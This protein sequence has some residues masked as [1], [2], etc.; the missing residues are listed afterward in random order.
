MCN[1]LPSPFSQQYS[2]RTWISRPPDVPLLWNRTCV[3]VVCSVSHP[4]VSRHWRETIS[5]ISSPTDL[6]KQHV[7]WC[8]SHYQRQQLLFAVEIWR[9]IPICTFVFCWSVSSVPSVLWRCWLGGRKGIQ[10][11][12]NRVVV[13]PFW[14]RLTQVVLEKKPLND[15]CC[16]SLFSRIC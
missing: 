9:R 15:C 11:A 12:K 13:L 8:T 14:Y 4:A 5:L 10:P 7:E 16:C 3:S 1:L 2:R 6:W